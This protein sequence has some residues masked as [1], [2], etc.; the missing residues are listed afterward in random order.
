MVKINDKFK[1]ELVNGHTV[2]V[3]S[4]DNSVCGTVDFN[5]IKTFLWGIS[6]ENNLTKQ[7]MLDKILNKFD[8]STVL[9]LGEIDHFIR[10]IKELGIVS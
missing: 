6:K 4:D 7:E 3:N 9:A 8:I 2:I 1:L 5:E 10:K